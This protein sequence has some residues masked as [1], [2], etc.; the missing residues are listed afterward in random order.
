[1]GPAL[2]GEPPQGLGRGHRPGNLQ[3]APTFA[4]CRL[5]G[6][7]PRRPAVSDRGP[8]EWGRRLT[9]CDAG[10]GQQLL[11]LRG[12]RRH[13]FDVA[14][15]P[16]GRRLASADEEGVIKFWDAGTGAE[17]LRFRGHTDQVRSVAFSPDGRRLAS[18][19]N[20]RTAKVWDAATGEEK[21]T[22]RGHKM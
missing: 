17:L 3:P 20:D 11:A 12:H 9:V 13:V 5:C 18:G 10:S 8:P 2:Q 1:L 4:G 22:L 21:L 16:A 6:V 14:F 19:S 7:Q 15:S